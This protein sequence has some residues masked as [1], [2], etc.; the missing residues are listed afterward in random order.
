M[1]FLIGLGITTAILATT[2][3]IG[4]YVYLKRVYRMLNRSVP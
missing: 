1:R 2:V 3:V 4:G